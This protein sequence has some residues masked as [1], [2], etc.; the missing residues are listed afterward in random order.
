MT[1][2][3]ATR[4][5]DSVLAAWLDEG[6]RDLPD[7]TRRAILTSLSTTPQARRGRL[8]PWRSPLMTMFARG[9]AILVVAVLAIGGLTLLSGSGRIGTPVPS[10]SPSATARTV[11]PCLVGTWT[12]LPLTQNSPADNESATFSGGAGEVFTID[13]QGNVTIDTH[14]AQKTVFVVAGQTFTATPSGTGHGTLWTLT[15]GAT[16]LF[17]YDPSPDS[18]LV[19]G[20]VGS[21]DG[22]LPPKLDV[23]FTADYTCTPGRSLTFYNSTPDQYMIDGA[24]VTLSA[25]AGSSPAVASPNPS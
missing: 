11:D 6:P 17:H 21:T 25:G 22:G 10:S 13:D 19:T 3:N 4:D 9:A 1:G 14:A 5:P 20:V 16:R 15:A 24:L 7:A 2:T 23:P 18:T 8:A 12:T